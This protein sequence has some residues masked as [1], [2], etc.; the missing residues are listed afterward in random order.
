MDRL[1]VD[2]R[3]LRPERKNIGG[4][5]FLFQIG[6]QNVGNIQAPAPW[7]AFMPKPRRTKYTA[8]FDPSNRTSDKAAMY[9]LSL[10]EQVS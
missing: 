3:T 7:N 5:L 9:L 2:R 4:K 1:Q 8:S 10:E 6:S